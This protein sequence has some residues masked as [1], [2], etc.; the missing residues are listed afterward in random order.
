[1]ATRTA[2]VLR[3]APATPADKPKETASIAPT[4][5]TSVDEIRLRAYRTWEA[6]GKPSGDGVKFWLEVEQELLQRK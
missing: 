5:P 3:S 2:K 6:A 4:Q 1:M